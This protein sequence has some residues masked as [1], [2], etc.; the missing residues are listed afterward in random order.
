MYLTSEI[1][2]D[3]F[4][5]SSGSE[6]NTGSSESQIA[7]FTFRINHLTNH[8]KANKHD[9]NTQRSLLNLVGKRR[10]LLDYVKRK[11]ILHYREIL[12]KLDIRK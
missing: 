1:K 5:K 11:D 12:K 7:L 4:K 10:A 3:I 6:K 2:K 9:A 8:L